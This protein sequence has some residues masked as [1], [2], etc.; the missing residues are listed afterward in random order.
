MGANQRNRKESKQP[1]G[2]VSIPVPEEWLDCVGEPWMKTTR[3][4]TEEMDFQ[5]VLLQ[6]VRKCPVKTGE[7]AER[8][9]DVIGSIKN[10]DDGH[11]LLAES[12][13]N[14]M[15]RLLKESAHQIWN[16]ADAATLFRY[17]RD[18]SEKDEPTKKV[19]ADE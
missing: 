12:D 4:G 2:I 19:P 16:P 17:V 9:L 7:D 11:I 15:L 3:D 8:A 18:E 5:D 6:T 13:Y 1:H 10:H 14:W